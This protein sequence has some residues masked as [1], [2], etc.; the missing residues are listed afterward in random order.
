MPDSVLT[1]VFIVKCFTYTFYELLQLSLCVFCIAIY[2]LIQLTKNANC[3]YTELCA[4]NHTFRKK[5][6][7]L[8][9]SKRQREK[10]GNMMKMSQ[11]VKMCYAWLGFLMATHGSSCSLHIL[12]PKMGPHEHFVRE[13]TFLK[14]VENW[15]WYTF[16]NSQS[17]KLVK[18]LTK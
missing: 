4:S 10:S 8:N 17:T 2:Q 15:I 6:S 11:F 12:Q 9:L 14:T 16:D 18:A 1:S 3:K 7:S 5:Y 13:G